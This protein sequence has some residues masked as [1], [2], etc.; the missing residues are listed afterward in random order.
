MIDD[1]D[2]RKRQLDEGRAGA[3]KINL[4]PGLHPAIAAKMWEAVMWEKIQ[5][6]QSWR[7]VAASAQDGLA[8]LGDMTPAFKMMANGYAQSARS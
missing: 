5:T 4:S 7:P 3:R 6:M 1:M 8:L 2:S